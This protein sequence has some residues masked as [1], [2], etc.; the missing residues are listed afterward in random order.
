MA[1]AATIGA[2]Y[3]APAYTYEQPL[4]RHVRAL[5][6]TAATEATWEVASVEPGLDLAAGRAGRLD[7]D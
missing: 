4:R 2:A 6:E 7:T 1:L 3:Q 5:Q